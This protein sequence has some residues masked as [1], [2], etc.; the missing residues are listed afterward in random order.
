[1]FQNCAWLNEPE[2]N[3]SAI[4]S[5]LRKKAIIRVFKQAC[6]IQE[7]EG[8]YLSHTHTGCNLRP[9]CTMIS[10]MNTSQLC[11]IRSEYSSTFRKSYNFIIVVPLLTN[12]C[13]LRQIRNY[14]WILQNNNDSNIYD[15][16]NPS[17]L[18]L[19][20]VDRTLLDMLFWLLT[21]ITEYKTLPP[22]RPGSENPGTGFFNWGNNEELM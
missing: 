6:E 13:T 9:S 22:L 16:S 7:R 19:W 11:L 14:L 15:D 1:M 5:N 18:I 10:G 12:K 3:I 20:V 2:D 17:S 8:T 4:R 21:C